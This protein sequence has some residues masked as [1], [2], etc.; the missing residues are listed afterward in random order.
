MM[1]RGFCGHRAGLTARQRALAG[2]VIPFTYGALS[3]PCSPLHLLT[4]IQSIPS[5]N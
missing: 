5:I 1:L 3:L 4:P 2:S